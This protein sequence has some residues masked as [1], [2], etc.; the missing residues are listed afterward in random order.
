MRITYFTLHAAEYLLQD[1][2]AWSQEVKCGL[3]YD[4][5]TF[6]RSVQ[7]L[8]NNAICKLELEL[9]LV[10]NVENRL[11]KSQAAIYL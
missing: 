6:R 9:Y 4:I 5:Y 8:N 1:I 10:Q 3:K 2:V 7:T 11:G